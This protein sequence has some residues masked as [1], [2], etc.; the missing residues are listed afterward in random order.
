MSLTATQTIKEVHDHGVKHADGSLRVIPENISVGT[1]VAQGDLNIICLEA[2]PPEAIPM[3]AKAQ[4]AEGVSRGS[5]HCIKAEDMAHCKFYGFIDP[6]PL[7]GPI[8]QFDKPTTIEHPE[9]GYQ[10]WPAGIIAITYQR[11]HAD[12]VR[13]TLD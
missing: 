10:L 7:E 9:H 5:R 12:E 2:I 6:S 1:V 11:R 8:I 4:L 3:S 13:R